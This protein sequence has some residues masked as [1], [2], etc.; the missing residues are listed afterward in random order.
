MFLFARVKQSP[1]ARAKQSPF[2][3]AIRSTSSSVF[4]C[5]GET[6]AIRED[7]TLAICAGKS[8]HLRGPL[9][10]R[11]RLFSFARVEHSPSVRVKVTICLIS[12]SVVPH[13]GS[14]RAA[15]FYI[16]STSFF[17]KRANEL[18]DW[19]VAAWLSA[20]DITSAETLHSS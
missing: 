17:L 13:R 9:G 5:G 11:S 20:R 6:V 16:L 15:A 12:A 3:R 7:G 4:I 1:F 18:F 8:H 10:R 2:A 14:G 19:P